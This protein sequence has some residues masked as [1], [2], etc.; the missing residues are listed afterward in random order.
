MATEKKKLQAY[1]DDELYTAF[2][3]WQ[4]D[5]KIRSE[6]EAMIFLLRLFLRNENYLID[7]ELLENENYFDVYQEIE[8]I[9]N[10]LD[11]LENKTEDLPPMTA[12]ELAK[13][14][15]S[16]P[17]TIGKKSKILSEEEFKIWTAELDPDKK[18]WHREENLYYCAS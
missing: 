4:K 3:Q 12:T 1:I 6:S 13:R 7:N 17:L 8:K 18:S 14:L 11:K 16:D 5:N 10:R 2:K 15:N 9:K